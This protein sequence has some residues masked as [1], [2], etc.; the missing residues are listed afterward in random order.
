MILSGLRRSRLNLSSKRIF[1]QTRPFCSATSD[2]GILH[3]EW[4]S[5]GK[6][7]RHRPPNVDGKNIV[8]FLHGLLGSGK[9]L[10]MPAKRLTKSNPNVD[11]LLIDLRGHGNTSASATLGTDGTKPP[12]TLE[13]CANDVIRTVSELGMIGP[14]SSPVG[15]IGHS[16]GGRLALEYLHKLLHAPADHPEEGDVH[17]PIS[18]WILDSVPGQAHKSVADVVDKVSSV[19]MPVRNKKELIYLLMQEKGVSEDIALWMTTN[20]TASPDG[21]GFV[22]AFDLNVVRDVLG[23]FPRQD[24]FG[25]TKDVGTKYVNFPNG[26]GSRGRKSKIGIVMA[27]K[28]EAWTPSVVDELESLNETLLPSDDPFLKTHWLENSGHNVHVDDLNG[29]MKLIE[30]D[31]G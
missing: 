16:F 10:R 30:R 11:A 13:T 5:D 8:L 3:H 26:V 29:L 20:L 4:V 25:L 19:E 6:L 22:W 7:S 18:T 2:A 27:G 28:N 21:E 1:Q 31:F 9:N 15:V 12:H 23:D 14:H 24:F 17:P